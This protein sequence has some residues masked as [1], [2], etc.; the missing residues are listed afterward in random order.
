M[1]TQKELAALSSTI[2]IARLALKGESV[3]TDDK[4]LRAYGLY[5]DWT[6]GNHT[7]GEVY[8]T[9]SSETLDANWEQVWECFQAY[10][11]AT[12]P[13]ISPGNSAWY[14]FNRP[15]HGTSAE[16]ARPFVT[17]QGAHDMYHSGEYAIWTD[18]ATYKCVQD[19]NFS[20][21]DYPQAWQKQ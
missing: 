10:D 5:P 12:Y 2:Y 19:T 8:C 6:A 18:G 20:P 11:N 3:D 13:D 16:T 1:M 7:V 9:H 4:K 14:T 21:S 17:V 15:L